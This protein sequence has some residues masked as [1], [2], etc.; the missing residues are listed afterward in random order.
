MIQGGKT[1]FQ[2]KL[3]RKKNETPRNIIKQLAKKT[4]RRRVNNFSRFKLAYISF[5]DIKQSFSKDKY[6]HL[7]WLVFYYEQCVLSTR[8][9][10]AYNLV[11]HLFAS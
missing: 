4:E 6:F 1:S 3:K 8:G 7:V 11:C 2:S 10:S 9:N 5:I